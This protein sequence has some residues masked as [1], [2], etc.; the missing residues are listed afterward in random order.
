MHPE[1]TCCIE[2]YADCIC[3]FID[4]QLD[5][6]MG[7]EFSARAKVSDDFGDASRTDEHA[8]HRPADGRYIDIEA[9]SFGGGGSAGAV[10]RQE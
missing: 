10:A 9:E 6:Y 4:T 1:S 5:E 8:S 7:E 2:F 3:S